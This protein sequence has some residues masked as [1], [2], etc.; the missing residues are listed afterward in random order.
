MSG[1]KKSIRE[2][3]AV[4]NSHEARIGRAVAALQAWCVLNARSYITICSTTDDRH[5]L[6]G[7][8]FSISQK[9]ILQGDEEESIN[10]CIRSLSKAIRRDE[11]TSDSVHPWQRGLDVNQHDRIVRAIAIAEAKFASAYSSLRVICRDIDDHCRQGDVFYIS[12]QNMLRFFG[13]DET[14]MLKYLEQK[15]RQSKLYGGTKSRWSPRRVADLIATLK[16]IE[17][18]RLQDVENIARSTL[19]QYGCE[20]TKYSI[21]IFSRGMRA[22]ASASGQIKL[23]LNYALRG[24]M[25]DIRNTI[26]HEVAH[27]LVGPR[28]GHRRIWQEKAKEMGVIIHRRY[29][30]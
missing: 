29:L 30:L 3:L 13:F 10:E 28:H 2:K 6:V 4:T 25:D 5:A 26:L 15:I 18:K 23:D 16:S 17:L 21:A 1:P 19:Q 12:R 14:G 20:N 11:K 7:D 24:N 27:I 9:K 8:A 22:C